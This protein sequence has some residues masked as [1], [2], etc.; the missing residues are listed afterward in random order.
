MAW[1]QRSTGGVRFRCCIGHLFLAAAG[2][3]MWSVPAVANTSSCSSTTPVSTGCAVVDS[4][5]FNPTINGLVNSYNGTFNQDDN[6]QVFEVDVT[7][8]AQLYAD[9][10][11]YGGGTDLT[12]AAITPGGFATEFSL[13]DTNGN[14]IE[15]SNISNCPV[16]GQQNNPSTNLCYDSA[17]TATLTA[18]TYYVALT[19]NNNDGTV[20]SC[21]FTGA[22]A[23]AATPA[24]TVNPAAFTEGGMG[25]FTA[26]EFGCG[27]PD[28]CDPFNDAMD[29]TYDLDIGLG[30]PEPASF[31]LVSMALVCGMFLLWRNRRL[32][33]G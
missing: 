14:F 20:G 29:G 7:G 12:G 11:S 28:F 17:L 25:N 1:Y 13:F 16:M 6:I 22:C 26:T 24:S 33:R 19:E 31:G 3:A 21:L 8:L 15:N 4:A 18:G 9:T 2:A 10:Y 27:Q 32:A 23:T 5:F 30:V